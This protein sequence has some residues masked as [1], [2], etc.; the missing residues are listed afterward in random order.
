MSQWDQE[1]QE[2]QEQEEQEDREQEEQEQEQQEARQQQEEEERDQQEQDQ[3][4]EQQQEQ[5]QVVQMPA[6]TISGPPQSVLNDPIKLIQWNALQTGI[7]HA[8]T[9]QPFNPPTDLSGDKTQAQAYEAGYRWARGELTLPPRQPG[10]VTV[11]TAPQIGP[12]T[13]PGHTY[14]HDET[15]GVR[16][17]R[18]FLGDIHEGH[19]HAPEPPEITP[20]PGVP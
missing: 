19:P 4:Q 16:L 17:I 13:T 18:E 20:G 8:Q 5:E 15:P 6:A 11:D 7:D 10:A 14:V 9:G 3:Q 1:Q 2:Q 12:E